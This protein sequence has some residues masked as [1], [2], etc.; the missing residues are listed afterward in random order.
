MR[1]HKTYIYILIVLL[2][3]SCL[4]SKND[5]LEKTNDTGISII[6]YDRM[7]YEFVSFDS[8]TALQN[9]NTTHSR[10]SQILVEDILNLGNFRDE[11]INLKVQE[12]Y[13]DTT[14]LRLMNDV[15]KKFTDL[16]EIEKD[17]TEGFKKLQKEVPSIKIPRIYAQISALNESIIVGDSLLGIS[18]DKYMGK[19]YPLY[20]R[21][22]YRYQ[23]LTMEPERI[24]P[25][26]FLYYMLSEYPLP[27]ASVGNLRDVMLHEA[28]IYYVVRKILNN[29]SPAD[30]LGYSDTEK[31][32][33]R[34]NNEMVWK[35]MLNNNHL[36]ATDPTIIRNYMRPL[37]YTPFWGESTP[38]N[39][40][41]WIGMEIVS[42]Y[43]K[44]N[45]SATLNDLLNIT[46]Y[47]M[48]LEKSEYSPD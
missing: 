25:D 16:T 40:G 20:P 24:V 12:Y 36:S 46:D 5:F 19:D 11:N 41:L 21:F 29:S 26:C 30:M 37:P 9:M 48:L 1:L 38:A 8:F 17:L 23:T 33:C 42:S 6:R 31:K 28:K 47:Q 3:S 18:L 34:D 27:R 35:F 7:Q 22:Y 2:F 14:L 4:K 44:K 32:W 10:I 13:S 39:T 43:M 45:K 15:E